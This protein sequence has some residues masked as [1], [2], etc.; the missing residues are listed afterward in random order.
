M[1]HAH[2]LPSSHR[3]RT[4]LERRRLKAAKLF[5]KGY[6]Q[7]K[8]ARILGVSC[9]AARKW[10]LVWKKKGV[11]GLK[12]RGKPGAKS[13]LTPDK[14]KDIEQAL[15]RGPTAFGYSTQIWTL[16]RIAQVAQRVANVTYH[17]GYIWYVLKNLNWTCQKPVTRASERNEEA[18]SRW[19]K[20]TWPRIKKK[21]A[22]LAQN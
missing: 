3:D 17:P 2:I 20:I 12:S 8:A 14:L 21:P 5:A 10:Q 6:S 22:E 9:E 7:T 1:N 11:I 19:K 18:I 16:A 15:L 13:A 4:V